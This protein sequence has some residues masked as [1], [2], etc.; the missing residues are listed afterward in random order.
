MMWPRVPRHAASLTRSRPSH[1][2]TT[3]RHLSAS[4]RS[5]TR[6]SVASTPARHAPLHA[7]G[8]APV[9][10][11][12]PQHAQISSQRV[13]VS[14]LPLS[15]LSLSS[16]TVAMTPLSSTATMLPPSHHVSSTPRP[17]HVQ[18]RHRIASSTPTLLCATPLTRLCRARSSPATQACALHCAVPSTSTR[19]CA[20]SRSR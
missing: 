3:T 12:A 4:S 13:I 20:R 18:H 16:S 14:H 11:V 17:P 1:P 2:A 19:S 10:H 6:C 5:M 8:T 7:R 9:T 15:A